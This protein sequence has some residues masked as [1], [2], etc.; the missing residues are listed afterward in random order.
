MASSTGA[1]KWDSGCKNSN[2]Q[3]NLY[4]IGGGGTTARKSSKGTTI[5]NIE[6][7]PSRSSGIFNF[8]VKIAATAK[9]D[10][11][12]T[13]GLKDTVD[14]HLR[15]SGCSVRLDTGEIYIG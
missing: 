8:A 1:F 11:Y 12:N 2:T 9:A 5:Y 13:V 10:P 6:G 14:G 7:G 3:P 15:S 4:T